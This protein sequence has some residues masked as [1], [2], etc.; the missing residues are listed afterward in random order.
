MR[1]HRKATLKLL[2]SEPADSLMA[3]RSV[4]CVQSMSSHYIN[5]TRFHFSGAGRDG[6]SNGR[7]RL[8]ASTVQLHSTRLE[9]TT[10]PIPVLRCSGEA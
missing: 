1:R 7:G 9:S 5:S 8:E 4:G 3:R 6:N 10:Q 2:K